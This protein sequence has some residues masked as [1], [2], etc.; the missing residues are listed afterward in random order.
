MPFD[1]LNSHPL[2]SFPAQLGRLDGN[3][4]TRVVECHYP[5]E[6]RDN[7]FQNLQTLPDEIGDAI[8]DAGESATRFCE[9]L[10][11]PKINRVGPGTKNDRDACRRPL[12]RY[13][14]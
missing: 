9:T 1:K 4:M 13:G 12:C 2:R 14:N 6:L 7:L 8:V 10:H 5:V 11:E 3:W